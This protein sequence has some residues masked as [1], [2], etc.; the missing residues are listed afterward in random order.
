MDARPCFDRGGEDCAKIVEP[1]F[2]DA[3]DRKKVSTRCWVAARHEAQRDIREN[4]VRRHVAFVGDLFPE[5]AE[6]FE[7]F[8]VALNGVGAI[9]L[10]AQTRIHRCRR[11]RL[12][13]DDCV[14]VAKCISATLRHVH[15]SETVR[16]KVEE[17]FL[18]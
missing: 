18:E 2:A 4:D 7:E 3:R 17:A 14:P 9:R 1:F 16:A 6:V 8:V 5:R 11:D 13:D 12:R 10:A 15:N